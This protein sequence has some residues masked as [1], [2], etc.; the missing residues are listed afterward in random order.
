MASSDVL[1]C[2][3]A[4]SKLGAERINAL[5]EDSPNGRSCNAAFVSVRDSELEDHP[6]S[7][8]I[9]RAQ[10]AANATAPIFGRTNAFPLP[11]DFI[12]LLPPYVEDNRNN[13]DHQIEAGEIVTDDDG[14]LD[15]RYIAR[16]TDPNKYTPLFA[17]ALSARLA[18]EM[19]E[20]ITQSNSKRQLAQTEYLAIVSRAKKSNAIQRVAQR[21]PR[22]V[23]ETVRE[24]PRIPFTNT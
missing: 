16:I 21:P 13:W 8:A 6:W 3:R 10:L 7:F 23:W 2:N 18:M 19:A 9:K 12:R 17:E 5:T 11:V 20:E 14:P 22:D 4:L 1:I 24:G 15:I